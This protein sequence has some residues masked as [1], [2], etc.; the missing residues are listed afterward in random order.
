MDSF[1]ALFR[2]INVGGRNVIPMKELASLMEECGYENIRTYIQGGNVVFNSKNIP[3]TEIEKLVE[4]KFGFKPEVLILSSKDLSQAIEN[5]PYSSVDGKLCHFY[6]CMSTP[7]SINTSKL[8]ELETASEE[9]FIKG[10]VFYLYAPVG[11]GRSKLAAGVESCLGILAVARN[12]NTVNKLS[13][14]LEN[15]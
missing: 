12:L 13:K 2:G 4:K 1:V 3:N 8:K 10:K 14:M 15:A 11:I 9:Y 5:N 7:K 6:F